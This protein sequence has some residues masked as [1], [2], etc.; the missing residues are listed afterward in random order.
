MEN[1]EKA[2]NF[3]ENAGEAKIPEAAASKPMENL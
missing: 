1:A 3:V 2:E